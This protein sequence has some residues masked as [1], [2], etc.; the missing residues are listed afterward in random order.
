VIV[1]GASTVKQPVQVPTP[2][3]VVTRTLPAPVAAPAEMAPSR[4]RRWRRWNRRQSLPMRPPP[5][6]VGGVS[7]INERLHPGGAPEGE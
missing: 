6:P 1:G 7:L 5:P 3:G 2:P 4:T